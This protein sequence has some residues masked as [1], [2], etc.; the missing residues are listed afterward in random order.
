[1]AYRRLK[2]IFPNTLQ[3]LR[4]YNSHV[5]DLYLIQKAARE[6][7]GLQVLTL[8]RCT[9]FT[10]TGCRFWNQLPCGESDAYFS[11]HQVVDY[12]VGLSVS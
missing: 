8:A 3:V 10:Q 2:V 9:L 6:C 11:N 1:M 4:V 12:A 5:P 7:P